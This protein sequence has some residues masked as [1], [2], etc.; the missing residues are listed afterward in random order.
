MSAKTRVTGRKLNSKSSIVAAETVQLDENEDRSGDENGDVGDGACN[1]GGERETGNSFN[2]ERI[3]EIIQQQLQ[4][5]VQQLTTL[6]QGQGEITAQLRTS[7]E[8]LTATVSMLK[9]NISQLKEEVDA[10][11]LEN[12]VFKKSF[13]Q[14]K[15]KDDEREQRGRNKSIRIYNVNTPN[16]LEEDTLKFAEHVYSEVIRPVLEKAHQDNVIKS[17]PTYDQV[18]EYTHPLHKHVTSGS[19]STTT[20]EAGANADG[21]TD[22]PIILRF[23]SRNYKV[24]FLKYKSSV[25]E[26]LN[27]RHNTNWF[28]QC[29]YTQARKKCMQRLR[30][31]K[32]VDAK[33]VCMR[34][35]TVKFC[36]LGDKKFLA[37]E[38]IFG[39][40]IADMLSL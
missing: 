29:D 28:A 37:V 40:T 13:L 35:T 3:T 24:A 6:E 9:S 1:G 21:P 8:N 23:V 15:L 11:K 20:Q 33:T 4:P 10:L 31:L 17:V 2:Y 34:G 25:F 7:I 5:V 22:P 12:S 36:K 14:V 39:E 32:E 38:N 19:G 27:A 26:N 30:K 18:V 16:K